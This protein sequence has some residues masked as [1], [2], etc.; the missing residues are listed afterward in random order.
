MV[1]QHDLGSARVSTGH[2]TDGLT[3]RPGCSLAKHHAPSGR[4]YLA[5]VAQRIAG[6]GIA[7]D[8][9]DVRRGADLAWCDVLRVTSGSP[10]PIHIAFTASGAI[11]PFVRGVSFAD[12]GSLDGLEPEQTRR[13]A[14]RL[15]V[16]RDSAPGTYDG[17]LTVAVVG[18]DERHEF[19]MT[20]TVLGPKPHPSASPSCSPERLGEPLVLAQ[21]VVLAQP[22]C[23]PSPSC[24]PTPAA[25]LVLAPGD[26]TVLAEPDA[27]PPPA[28]R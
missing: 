27:S 17:T 7:L 8:F 20:I 19:P 14:V 25:I 5:P 26:S 24:S 16:P 9:G 28:D 18:D 23:S 21:P 10:A 15:A 4:P 2:W 1:L 13:I 22:S 12:A 3:F 11:A 6:G